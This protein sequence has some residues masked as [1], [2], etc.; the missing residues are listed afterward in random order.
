MMEPTLISVLAVKS[1]RKLELIGDHRQLPAFIQNCWFNLECT[2]PSI[3]TSLFERLISSVSS[4][5]G[6]SGIGALEQPSAVPHTVL[7]EQRRM[8]SSIADITRP[9]YSDVV[10][11]TDHVQTSKQLIGDAALLTERPGLRMHRALWGDRPRGVPGIRPTVFFWDL[12][13]NKESR[14]MAGLSAC[15]E[16]EANAATELTKWFLLC[17]VPPSSIS[18]ITPY[19]GQKTLIIKKLRAA[20]CLPS[21]KDIPPPVGSTVNVSTVDRYQGDENDIIIYSNVRIRP[22]N[23]FVVLK[24]RFIVATSR[25]RMG[26]YIIGS[27]DAVL[28]GPAGKP[29]PPHWVSFVEQLRQTNHREAEEDI[30]LDP[31][32]TWTCYY[33]DEDNSVLDIKPPT[34]PKSDCTYDGSRVGPSLPICCPRH[35]TTMRVVRDVTKFPTQGSWAQFCKE[36]CGNT[37]LLCGHGCALPCHSP[38]SVKHTVQA[39][40]TSPLER[41]CKAHSHIPLLCKELSFGRGDTIATALLKSDCQI[42]EPY[43]RPECD[44]IINLPCHLLKCMESEPKPAIAACSVIVNDFIQPGCGHI[45]K[46]PTCFNRR[47]YEAEPPPCKEKVRHERTCGCSIVLT[48]EDNDKERANPTQCMSSMTTFRPRCFHPLSVRCHLGTTLHTLWSQQNGEAVKQKNPKTIVEYGVSYGPSEKDLLGARLTTPICSTSSTYR[49]SCGH[50]IGDIPCD[51]AFDYAAGRSPEPVCDSDVTFLSPLC[52]HSV[53]V[54]CWARRAL[55][56]WM[57]WGQWGK[58]EQIFED[59][60][61]KAGTA[62]LPMKVMKVL[63]NI[64]A[65]GVQVHRLCGRDHLKRVP[66]GDLYLYLT[67]GKRLPI[68]E[69]LFNRPLPCGHPV[70][71][72]CHQCDDPYPECKMPVQE[73]FGY[74]C[75]EHTLSGLTCGKLTHLKTSID[76]KCPNTVTCTRYLCGHSVRAACHLKPKITEHLPGEHLLPVAERIGQQVVVADTLY[77]SP[78]RYVDPCVNQVTYC[79]P[80]GHYRPD[81]RCCDA[82]FWA[83]NTCP[84]P[85]M[86]QVPLMSPLCGHSIKVACPKSDLVRRWRPWQGGRAEAEE[87]FGGHVLPPFETV[88]DCDEHG[89]TVTQIVVK[90]DGIQPSAAIVPVEELL[91]DGRALMIRGKSFQHASKDDSS[92]NQRLLTCVYFFYCKCVYYF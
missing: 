50:L 67:E 81:V 40:C 31:D 8:R 9:H 44:H 91:C 38:T 80:C 45:I 23:K 76:P 14:P 41:S 52:G 10:T 51:K 19:K 16:M 34:P 28:K 83:A 43:R 73:I 39:E 68:C 37:L 86:D 59:A 46:A 53:T 7:D 1:L 56:E 75:G 77:C 64:C 62:K 3:K 32:G 12:A 42:R 79:F 65:V 22:G 90:H 27:V 11:I 66:C 35:H 47:K 71:V 92:D 72:K 26:F 60:L 82:F 5:D 63:R 88:A 78:A 17:G 13:D 85:C 74:P 15:N 25:A 24:N 21:F 29:G 33:S 54:P 70:R 89:Q 18:V 6:R 55:T 4:R 84:D 57:P 58:P 36:P 49:A 48:C 20:K 2:L 61:L 30:N 87:E 69:E